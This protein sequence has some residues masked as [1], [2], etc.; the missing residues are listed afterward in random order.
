MAV[1]YACL[2][3]KRPMPDS[4]LIPIQNEFGLLRFRVSRHSI[5]ALRCA[6]TAVAQGWYAGRV[7][8]EMAVT[9]KIGIETCSWNVAIS[10]RGLPSESGRE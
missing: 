8:C 3:G 7:E 4:E 1:D 2:P 6:R 5:L 9:R 10:N